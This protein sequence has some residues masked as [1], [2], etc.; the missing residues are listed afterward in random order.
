[1]APKN[2]QKQKSF[3]PPRPIKSTTNKDVPGAKAKSSTA[4]PTVSSNSRSQT[5]VISSGSDAEYSE[6]DA[7]EESNPQEKPPTRTV[8]EEKPPIPFKLLARLLH[9]SFSDKDMR[10]GKEAMNMFTQ[11]IEV[12]LREAYARAAHEQQAMEK[13][14]GISDGFLQV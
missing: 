8:N 13:E 6:D 14:A 3:K 1:M 10:I 9:D 11:Y 5:A 7:E 4:K 2:V 12:F